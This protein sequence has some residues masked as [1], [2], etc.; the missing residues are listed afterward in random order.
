MTDIPFLINP[1]I[2]SQ[3]DGFETLTEAQIDHANMAVF[4]IV[5]TDIRFNRF[6]EANKHRSFLKAPE[7]LGHETFDA[8]TGSWETSAEEF[9][10]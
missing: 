3:I 4:R 8:N 10:V 7:R 9:S 5:S 6:Y 2:L 1:R